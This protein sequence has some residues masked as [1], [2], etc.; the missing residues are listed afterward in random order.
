MTPECTG[1]CLDRRGALTAAAVAGV[2]IPFLAACGDGSTAK[3]SAAPSGTT[4]TTTDAVPV[5]GGVVLGE[6]NVIVVQPEEGE[7]K[8]FSS[9]CPHQRCQ[10]SGVQ[11][12]EIVCHCHDSH[13]SL[14][15]GA[16]TSG[17]AREPLGEVRI[18]VSGN[19][20]QIA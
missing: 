14:D 8:A 16:P 6:E 11:D 18:T 3:P 7:F 2:G 20:I 9:V 13:F 17:P 1:P 5:E 12:G 4:L 10:V 15:D 19:D